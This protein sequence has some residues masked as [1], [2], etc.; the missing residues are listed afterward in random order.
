MASSSSAPLLSPFDADSPTASTSRLP[1]PVP[2]SLS[3]LPPELKALIVQKV[4]ELDMAEEEEAGDEEDEG[5]SDDEEEEEEEED[6]PTSEE[7]EGQG[8]QM[9]GKGAKTTWETLTALPRGPDG[10]PTDEALEKVR[11][12]LLQL[13]QPSGIEALTL[14]NREFSAMA[15]MWMWREL[16]FTSLSNE[17]LLHLIHHVLPHRSV[18][19]QS[20]AFGQCEAHMLRTD[21]PGTT[22]AYDAVDPYLP[23]PAARLRVVDAAERFGGVSATLP[24]GTVLSSEI[25]CRRTR[26]LLVAEVIRLCPNLVRVDCEGFPRVPPAWVDDLD[27]RDLD[28]PN[29]VY[30]VDHA[31]EALKVHARRGTLTDL[32]FLV[33]DDGITNEGDVAALLQTMPHLLRLQLEML[34]P[35]ALRSNRLALFN[36]FPAFT[37]LETLHIVEGASFVNDEFA[38]LSL[39][40]LPLKVLALGECADLSWEGWWTLIHQ[41]RNTLEVLDLDGTPHANNDDDN[42]LYLTSGKKGPLDLPKLDTLVLSTPHPFPFLL[43]LFSSCP[44]STFGLGFCPAIEYHD[45]EKFMDLHLDTLRRIEVKSDA[46]LSEAQVESLEVLCY[47]RGIECELV[48]GDENEDSDLDGPSAFGTDMDDDEVEV[49]TEDDDD[50][51]G[52]D[53]DGEDG[54]GDE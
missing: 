18:H 12:R 1:P 52:G 48:E 49:W 23:I 7:R 28:D 22:G 5:W 39:G 9:A 40:H 37:R 31:I 51:L 53:D 36:S 42:D 33:Q 46:A 13:A 47:G 21:P 34:V 29:V 4:A 24:D 14:V 32:T 8:S 27:D 3:T 6:E 10:N 45:I 50:G 17:S 35:S 44:I 25:R 19:V 2:A 11:E 41:F 20:L 16:D 15:M 38:Q 54:W 26:S 43:H 30:S